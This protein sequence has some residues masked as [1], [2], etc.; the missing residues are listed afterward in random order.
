M[1]RLKQTTEGWI[2]EVVE[3]KSSKVGEEQMLRSQARRLQFSVHFLGAL[4]GVKGRL[5]HLVGRP[6]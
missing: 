1:A 4:L 2:L 5:I 3:V 6:S